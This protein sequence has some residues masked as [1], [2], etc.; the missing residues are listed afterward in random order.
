VGAQNTKK[1]M[2]H[3]T[4]EFGRLVSDS[5]DFLLINKGMSGRQEGETKCFD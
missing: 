4:R 3:T 5:L 1:M 2:G